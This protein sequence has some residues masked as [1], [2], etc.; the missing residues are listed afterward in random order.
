MRGH[1]TIEISQLGELRTTDEL[2]GVYVHVDLG[3]PG[4]AVE[5][6][7]AALYALIAEARCPV[8]GSRRERRAGVAT[9]ATQWLWTQRHNRSASMSNTS[10]PVIIATSP[11]AT[12]DEPCR[13]QASIESCCGAVDLR[14]AAGFT[15]SGSVAMRRTI[16]SASRAI[17]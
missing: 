3:S 11:T 8:I 14:D 13:G 10:K 12:A 9:T 1:K 5:L 6:M 17:T 7:K 4:I 15:L 16:G 2:E